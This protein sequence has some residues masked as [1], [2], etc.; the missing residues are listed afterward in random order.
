MNIK[1]EDIYYEY[2]DNLSII[3]AEHKIPIIGV[4]GEGKCKEKKL[5]CMKCIE[6]S[7]SEDV[8]LTST[9]NNN[10]KLNNIKKQ[11]IPCLKEEEDLHEII[12]IG[13]LFKKFFNESIENNSNKSNY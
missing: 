4:C 12:T 8:N 13:S 11:V 6:S 3:C 2:F 1:K 9:I 5:L 10:N 7:N